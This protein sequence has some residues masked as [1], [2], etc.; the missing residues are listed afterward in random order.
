[1]GKGVGDLRCRS[2]TPAEGPGSP[3]FPTQSDC[4]LLCLSPCVP[5]RLTPGL[6]A[7]LHQAPAP[8][9]WWPHLRAR[10]WVWHGHTDACVP[11]RPLTGCEHLCNDPSVS[12]DFN[13]ADP[14][15][16]WDS[17]E[18]LSAD[19]EGACACLVSS[20]FRS[21]EPPEAAGRLHSLLSWRCGTHALWVWGARGTR[22]GN[23]ALTAMTGAGRAVRSPTRAS[24]PDVAQGMLLG[25]SRLLLSLP[26]VC[27]VPDVCSGPSPGQQ[28]LGFISVC[29]SLCC[30]A[31]MAAS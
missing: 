22:P 3:S 23:W 18:N 24:V 27:G 2:C 31:F 8:R 20:T 9:F 25:P 1:M 6:G 26:A 13:T 30:P 14:L 5:G 12:V 21:E 16:R 28:A 19:G 10:A 4:C 17:Y 15:I 7:G 11:P 29:L